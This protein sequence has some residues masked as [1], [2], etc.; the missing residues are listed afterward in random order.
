AAGAIR[1][2]ENHEG[3]LYPVV[4]HEMCIGCGACDRAC[5]RLDEYPVAY[6]AMCHS[7]HIREK[8]SSGGVFHL[9]AEKILRQGG[10]VYGAAFDENF[11]VC[12]CRVDNIDD[13]EKLQGS[14]YVQSRI[15]E[16]F[17]DV[18]SQL[19]TGRL[20]LFSGTPCQC[21][22]LV[23]YL[24]KSYANLYVVDFICHGVP[25]P[26][27]WRSYVQYVA[28][29]K[30]GTQISH[31]SFRSKNL[32][33]ERYLLEFTFANSSK[34]RNDLYT[35]IYL[36]GFLKD[37][38]LRKS[39]YECTSRK[40]HRG[41]DVTV[42]D[43]WGVQDVLPDMY[44]GRGT[45]LVLVHSDKGQ[46]LFDGIDARISRVNFAEAIRRNPAYFCSPG[47]H[48]KRDVFFK[49][50]E[51][52]EELVPLLEELLKEPLKCRVKNRLRSIKVLRDIYHCIRK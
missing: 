24:G 10:A 26:A 35:D 34:Y 52:G 18:K 23:S 28:G 44:D 20:V 4:N 2:A 43:F 1:M 17:H 49:R 47:I 16:I 25:S 29:L 8:S 41:S 51:A 33:W 14:K 30:K 11:E 5:P 9:L 48:P 37:L 7:V 3:F 50:L 15:G 39:C 42:A 27:V 19:A 6:A 46:R 12:H 21:E 38:Y 40:L 13:L 45:S 22:G 32:S 36:R 31:V